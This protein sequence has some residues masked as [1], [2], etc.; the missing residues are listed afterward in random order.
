MQALPRLHM[1]RKGNNRALN[2][3]GIFVFLWDRKLFSQDYVNW[4]VQDLNHYYY[5]Y[6][7]FYHH[8]LLSGLRELD[9]AGP[10]HYYYYHLYHYHYYHYY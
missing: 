1:A 2:P 3:V 10:N 8:L 4:I 5:Y 9:C 6:L 7:Y